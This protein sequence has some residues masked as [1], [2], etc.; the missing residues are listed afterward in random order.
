MDA[1]SQQDII[2]S[3][4]SVGS[5]YE[6]S[7]GQ[8]SAIND[9]AEVAV[10]LQQI[11]PVVTRE[12]PNFPQLLAVCTQ[13]QASTYQS[14]IAQ[15][16]LIGTFAASV[17]GVLGQI[18][19]GLASVPDDAPL[20]PSQAFLCRVQFEAFANHAGAV[21]TNVAGLVPDLAA[22]TAQN[23]AADASLQAIAQQLP[24]SWQSVAGP[25]Q[26]IS[27]SLTEVA[28]GWNNI[29]A[30]LQQLATGDVT[31]ATTGAARSAIA[32]AIPAWTGLG[33]AAAVF[34]H[35]ATNP[36]G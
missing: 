33:Q 26:Q 14:L 20:S 8:W 12:I 19:T 17:P 23:L 25:L 21:Q 2:P 18:V 1:T 11:G 5:L 36:G 31:F 6:I 10:S 35:N 24:S 4:G 9:Q 3:P 28:G 34:D 32:G 29:V 16:V 22:F 15:S 13:W 27:V 7:H 30:Q